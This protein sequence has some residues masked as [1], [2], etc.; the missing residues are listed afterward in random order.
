VPGAS[1]LRNLKVSGSRPGIWAEGSAASLTLKDVLIDDAQLAG[2]LV[3]SGAKITGTSVVV[4]GTQPQAGTQVS[5]RGISVEVDEGTKRRVR[6]P[7]GIATERG[8]G[9]GAH[10]L[11][12]SRAPTSCSISSLA[13]TTTAARWLA[14][15]TPEQAVGLECSATGQALPSALQAGR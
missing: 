4:R 3:L 9:S 13:A 6:R 7:S 5:G 15:G 14:A 12:R 1:T 10:H 8:L 2:L 11:D